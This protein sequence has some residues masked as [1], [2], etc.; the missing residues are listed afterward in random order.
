M[1]G[2]GDVEIWQWLVSVAITLVI[3]LIGIIEFGRAEK[4]FADTI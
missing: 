3:F 4:N 1:M 2:K